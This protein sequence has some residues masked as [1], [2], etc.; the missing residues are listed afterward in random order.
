MKILQLLL[1]IGLG[2]GT[3][4]AADLVAPLTPKT[5]AKSG[6]QDLTL[7]EAVQTAL[8]QSPTVIVAEKEIERTRGQFIQ[9]RAQALPQVGI[10]Y[11]YI[12]Q[13]RSLLQSSLLTS[14]NHAD[15]TVSG[16]N[17]PPIYFPTVNWSI[18]FEAKQVLYSGGQVTAGIRMARLT[19]DQTIF[20]LRDT[21]DTIIS[22]VRQQFAQV[23]V[24]KA[25]IRVQ[26]EQ[27]DLLQS[28]LSDQQSRFQAGT[29][30]SFNVLQAQ[31]ALANALPALIQAKNNYHI[32]Q[33]QLAK[34]LGYETNDLAAK[35][36]PFNVIGE[37]TMLAPRLDL[38]AG[39][40]QARERRPSLK[41]QRQNILIE[42]QD[43]IVQSAGYKPTLN[44]TTGYTVENSQLSSSLSD[45][46]SGFF[47]GFQGNWAIFDGLATY[48]NIKQANAKLAQARVNYEDS[49]QQVDLDVQQAWANLQQAK[50]TV[51]SQVKTV[52][53]ATEA[54]RLS[55][56]RLAAGAGT[57]LDVLS[58][59]VALAQAQTTELQARF[60]YIAA[61]AILDQV[62]ASDTKYN[63]TFDDPLSH[64]CPR[65][66]TGLPH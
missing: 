28:Q 34:T 43:V 13:D 3:L 39:L 56:E 19:E 62:T 29:V 10:A 11:S 46:I 23:L 47:F 4:L 25:L 41:A 53:Q 24:D 59:T 58:S 32:A 63:E 22:T 35:Q 9:V 51:A 65:K 40:K 37:L 1:L 6:S 66:F 48:G 30:P 60:T 12:Q 42:L 36:E 2:S 18:S 31:V 16:S 64:K 50:E 57:Q 15:T 55:R 26:E 44:A 52:E 49:I 27:V 14:N 33:L 8:R 5:L 61:L 21:V 7:D 45:T 54:V 38:A 17:A 20:K